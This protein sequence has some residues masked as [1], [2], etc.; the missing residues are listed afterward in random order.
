MLI[1]NFNN[2]IKGKTIKGIPIVITID[3]FKNS[4]NVNISIFL[5]KL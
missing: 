4:K 5:F 1:N 2:N 3:S